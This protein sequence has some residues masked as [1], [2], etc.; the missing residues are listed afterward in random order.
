MH[1]KSLDKGPV[2]K[3][4]IKMGEEEKGQKTILTVGS[5]VH[6]KILFPPRLES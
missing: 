2:S 5:K 6:K 4:Y 3:S 1:L